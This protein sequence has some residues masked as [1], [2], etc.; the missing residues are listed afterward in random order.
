MVVNRV[1][2][3]N[4]DKPESLEAALQGETRISD[5]ENEVLAGGSPPGF[6]HGSWRR[7][8]LVEV[9]KISLNPSSG[10]NMRVNRKTAFFPSGRK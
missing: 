2:Q 10:S 9:I 1:G 4:Q 5:P 6:L 7:G 8:H 3:Q